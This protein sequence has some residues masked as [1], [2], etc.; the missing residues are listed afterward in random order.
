[1]QDA[2]DAQ[3]VENISKE[4]CLKYTYT[5]AYLQYL[6]KLSQGNIMKIE[7]KKYLEKK[8]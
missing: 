7:E 3:W 5:H 6:M 1:M 2:L 4:V 8:C